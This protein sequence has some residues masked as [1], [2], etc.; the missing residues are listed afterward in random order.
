MQE[1]QIMN[2]VALA[3]IAF[4]AAYW[5]A[6][7]RKG[8][9]FRRV[10]QVF[11]GLTLLLAGLGKLSF[12]SGIWSPVLPV[13]WMSPRETVEQMT[14]VHLQALAAFT[15]YVQ[16]LAGLLLL[17]RR[18]ATLG[19]VL[20]FPLCVVTALVATDL[21]WIGAAM[22]AA[23]FALILAGLL[24]ADWSKLR[25][26]MV[27]TDE[28]DEPQFRLRHGNIDTLWVAGAVNMVV[29]VLAL[30]NAG[31]GKGASAVLF[32][33]FASVSLVVMS[34]CAWLYIKAERLT[35]SSA[36]S[37]SLSSDALGS[38]GHHDHHHDH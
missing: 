23:L 27:D 16:V 6:S 17:S 11:V 33:I 15:P 7:K 13:V 34:V 30:T 31:G 5:L 36:A 20:A 35:S 2:L 18:F 8:L 21:G 22:I 24:L 4:G 10:L 25:L 26:L 9:A 38:R 37:N 28:M 1:W 29:A 19:A 12:A 14:R 3:G 32:Y